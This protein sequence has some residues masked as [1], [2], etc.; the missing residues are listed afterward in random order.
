MTNSL[1]RTLHISIGAIALAACSTPSQQE[2]IQAT[3]LK[4]L[5]PLRTEFNGVVMGFDF[6]GDTTLLVSIDIQ[7]W[8]GLDD[9]AA[10]NAK[11]QIVKQAQA[12]WIAAHPNQQATVTVRLIDFIGRT[13]Y[14]ET[15]KI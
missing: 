10:A 5:A 15:A 1:R 14:Q 13:I 3:E 2:Q 12:A 11:R 8:I 7:N 6:K 9:D 4:Q